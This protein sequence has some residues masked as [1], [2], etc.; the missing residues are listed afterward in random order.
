MDKYLQQLLQD[1]RE[2]TQKITWSYPLSQTDATAL[3]DWLPDT[4][5][6]KTAPRISL[7]EWTGIQQSQFPPADRLSDEQIDLLFGAI[8]KMLSAFNYHVTFLFTL[9]NRTK[10]EVVRTH[11]KQEAIQKRFHMGF[12]ELCFANKSHSDCLMGTECHCAYFEELSEK[13]INNDLTPEEEFK[14]SIEE[15]KQR[16]KKKYGDDY[17]KYYPFKL[18]SKDNESDNV[19]DEDSGESKEED[20]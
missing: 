13:W 11:F 15:E 3:E 5:E 17:M 19:S 16:L 1:L 2:A 7:E 6:E 9:P 8:K 18:P 10:Y 12:F 4:E 20:C 14:K